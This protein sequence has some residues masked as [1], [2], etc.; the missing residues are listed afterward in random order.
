MTRGTP[1]LAERARDLAGKVNAD[2][3]LRIPPPQ[4]F[5]L[6]GVDVMLKANY[7]PILLEVRAG[8]PSPAP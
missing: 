6:I 7:S 5:H 3:A 8:F 2:L 4:S 1:R